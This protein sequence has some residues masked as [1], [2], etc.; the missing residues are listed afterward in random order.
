MNIGSGVSH[1]LREIL[2][3]VC[4]SVGAP[5]RVEHAAANADEPSL[6]LADTEHF[7]ALTGIRPNTD[8]A[9]I[10][11][12]QV[13]AQ[14]EGRATDS[15]PT[16]IVLVLQAPDLEGGRPPRRLDARDVDGALREARAAE[17]R[18]QV[19]L[20]EHRPAEQ[21]AGGGVD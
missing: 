13:D 21:A 19:E 17:G 2:D 14:L 4:A 11:R 12:R 18:R 20:D 15:Q 8:L 16:E 10:V 3:A 5:A 6:T 1:T 7:V 9:R